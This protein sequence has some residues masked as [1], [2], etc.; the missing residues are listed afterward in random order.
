[1]GTSTP[2]RSSCSR[3]AGTACAASGVLT[4]MRTI[5]EPAAASSFTCMA[6]PMA[7]AGS[8]VVMDCTTTGAPPPLCTARRP[9]R[10]VAMRVGRRAAAPTT[11][12][13]ALQGVLSV[14][15][16]NGLEPVE[17][18]PGFGHPAA[19]DR[20]EG[21]DHEQCHDDE[22]PAPWPVRSFRR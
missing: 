2:M 11:E 17:D 13:L 21:G 12:G 15:V 22:E 6:V 7:S 20:I 9:Q 8:A 3:M 14:I 5:S 18:Q 4:V 19:I 10:T 16:R 1:S